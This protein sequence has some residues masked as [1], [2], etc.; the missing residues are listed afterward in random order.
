MIGVPLALLSARPVA[1]ALTT[2]EVDECRAT[3]DL[4]EIEMLG[5]VV[6]E[7]VLFAY[8]IVVMHVLVEEWYVPALEL[9]TAPDIL[10]IPRPL[11]GCTIMAAGNCLP[12]LSMSLAAI[13]SGSQDV[14]TGEVF[15]SCVFDLLG[16]LGAVA[17]FS[18]AGPTGIEI[19]PSLVYFFLGWVAFGTVVDASLF[20]ADAET[21]WPVSMMMLALYGGFVASIFLCWRLI[22]G[23]V[24]GDEVASRAGA[25]AHT[26]AALTSTCK[27]VEASS[28]ASPAGALAAGAPTAASFSS[29]PLR[30]DWRPALPI[31]APPA[32]AGS[33]PRLPVVGAR[34]STALLPPDRPL[35][36]AFD[37]Y[38]DVVAAPPRLLFS[39]T[40]PQA[41][42]RLAVFGG[43]R[44]WP[45][46]LLLCITYTLLLSYAMV[47]IATRGI[48]LLGVRKNA[49]G[50]TLLCLSAG[51]P[52]LITAMVLVKRPGM[53]TMAAA[54]PFGAFVFN[55]FV[56]LGL[57]WLILGSHADIFPP[58]RGTW[59]PS[60]VGFCA[61]ALAVCGILAC[62]LKLTRSLGVALLTLYVG[63]LVVIIHDGTTR[64]ARPPA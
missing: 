63:Y 47:A 23:F 52:D 58:A 21:M 27:D 17:L 39:Y 37:R 20:F 24:G 5:G 34:E 33:P 31:G 59:F 43:Q 46:T 30:S 11:L 6:L 50:A 54:N 1:A 4:F 2:A 10:D 12:E 64:P 16:I 38:F 14:G 62:Q 48:C 18:P 15:G 29:S 22:P 45:L 60:L 53:Q 49:L 57:P 28:A 13:L 55:S 61:I 44:P 51:F 41:H 56:A 7:L 36:R 19:A 35:S 3:A 25:A 9:I 26:T 40:V 42:A 8:A 32:A